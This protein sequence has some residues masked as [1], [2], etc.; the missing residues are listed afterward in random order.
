MANAPAVD[1]SHAAFIR[2]GPPTPY[3]PRLVSLPLR[4]IIL[5]ILSAS[6]SPPVDGS[7]IEACTARSNSCAS[8]NALKSAHIP[9]ASEGTVKLRRIAS[10]KSASSV[11][12]SIPGESTSAAAYDGS[13]AGRCEGMTAAGAVRA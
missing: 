3:P 7:V 2:L 4:L 13:D 8:C 12:V 6:V 1:A 10:D 9:P 5:T 11:P